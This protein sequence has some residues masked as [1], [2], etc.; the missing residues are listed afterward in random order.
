[1]AHRCSLLKENTMNSIRNLV[2]SAISV[3]GAI[4]KT[5]ISFVFCGLEL[6][7]G[8]AACLSDLQ[9]EAKRDGGVKVSYCFSFQDEDEEYHD[10]DDVDDGDACELLISKNFQDIYNQADAWRGDGREMFLSVINQ[11]KVQNLF[12]WF[13]QVVYDWND[14][15]KCDDDEWDYDD[16]S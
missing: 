6:T 10:Y 9:I 4:S 15:R 13:D 5:K 8:S 3:R 14:R 2:E 1:M 16:D 7:K 12:E 11:Q